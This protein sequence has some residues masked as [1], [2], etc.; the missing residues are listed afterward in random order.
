MVANVVQELTGEVEYGV[1]DIIDEVESEADN[2]INRAWDDILEILAT[3]LRP[4][5]NVTATH[6]N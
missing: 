2:V 3:I 5:E 4:H 1:K 6:T